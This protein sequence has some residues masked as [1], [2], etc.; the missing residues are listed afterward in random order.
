MLGR[1]VLTSL[2]NCLLQR[3]HKHKAVREEGLE[4]PTSSRDSAAIG[5]QIT[6]DMFGRS[7][8][9]GIDIVDLKLKRQAASMSYH[10]GDI[11]M[12]TCI[13][14]CNIHTHI[15]LLCDIDCLN[16]QK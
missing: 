3:R 11:C 13:C 12:H 2:R 10:A 9:F 8:L 7:L 14:H 5:M 6:P 15:Q 4:Q 16:K 1:G